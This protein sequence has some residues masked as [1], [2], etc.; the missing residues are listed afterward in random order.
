MRTLHL[1]LLSPVFATAALMLAVVSCCY[2][3]VTPLMLLHHLCCYPTTIDVTPLQSTHDFCMQSHKLCCDTSPPIICEHSNS[4]ELYSEFFTVSVQK[5]IGDCSWYRAHNCL[6]FG[7]RFS[8]GFHQR[9]V[10]C[11]SY[12]CIRFSDSFHQCFVLRIFIGT[13]NLDERFV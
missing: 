3:A 2:T 8:D 13:A 1:V 4:Y 11:A 7:L 12:V 10:C 6:L 9:F 5:T